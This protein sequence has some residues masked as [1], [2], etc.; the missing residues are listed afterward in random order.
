MTKSELIDRLG[1]R[2]PDM[3]RGDVE[4]AANLILDQ[5]IETLA[6]G[7]G[8]VEIRGFGSFSLHY[9]PARRGRNPKTG[10]AVDIPSKYLP[11]FKPGKELSERVNTVR[12]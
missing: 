8:R 3:A 7:R 12:R 9:R 2:R 4:R 5:M 10:G 1:D 11:H 6:E